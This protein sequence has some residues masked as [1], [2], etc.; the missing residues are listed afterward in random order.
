ME[1]KYSCNFCD[2]KYNSL[3]GLKKHIKNK[4]PS[5]D[6]KPQK[7]H[8]CNFCGKIFKH[9]Q[10]KWYH[11]QSCLENNNIPLTEQVK[12]LTEK[13]IKLEHKT[14]NTSTINSN[15]TL[16]TTNNTTN[17]NN[18]QNV[19]CVFPLGN[20]PANALSLEY[21]KKTLS[22][23]G[24]NSVMEI[25]KKKH[26]NPALP[27]CQNFCVTALNNNYASVVDPETKTIKAV[28]K[29]DVFDKVYMGVVSNVNQV[30]PPNENVKETIDKIN[31][32][33]V[34]KKI[35][36]KLHCGLNEEAYH[37]RDLVKK[38]WK[39]AKFAEKTNQ[40]VKRKSFDL[41][42][43]S[44]VLDSDDE[45]V[46]SSSSDGSGFALKKSQVKTKQFTGPNQNYS[47]KG[48]Y[49]PLQGHKEKVISQIQQLLDEINSKSDFFH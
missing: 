24:I 46:S 21:I 31:N 39:S 40:E 45:S 25:V 19:I 18:T 2:S 41:N 7:I 1:Y 9:R 44:D 37:N 12:L 47:S 23:F 38:T 10:S 34:S 6:I 36:K 32:I 17:N 16:N 15:N 48:T 42:D 28:N 20:E 11:E 27:E 13:V 43:V 26:F 3:Q 5:N 30:V 33:P 14:P 35:L 49:T 29:K 8:D 4:H 22:E